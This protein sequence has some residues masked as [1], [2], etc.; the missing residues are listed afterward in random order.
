MKFNKLT[1]VSASVLLTTSVFAHANLDKDLSLDKPVNKVAKYKHQ[2][3]DFGSYVIQRDLAYVSASVANSES[4]IS[5]NGNMAVVKANSPVEY[6]G[7]GTLVKNTFTNEISPLSGNISVLLKAGISANEVSSATGL[8]VV[9]SY[10]GT[11]IA[12]LKVTGKQDIIEAR[13][14]LKASGLVKVAKIEVLEIL[15]KE[16]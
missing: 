7:K 1:A 15:H 3:A 13:N 5:T 4:I 16:Q 9:S 12:V 6:V 14:Q 2:K 11:Q 8:E 10:A